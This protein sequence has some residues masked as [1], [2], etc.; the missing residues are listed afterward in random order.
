M[1]KKNDK[2]KE[3]AESIAQHELRKKYCI[4]DFESGWDACLKY[5]AKLP[6]NKAMNEIADFVKTNMS[7]KSKNE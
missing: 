1:S 5:L 6:W 7:N 4:E 2:A 3:Y